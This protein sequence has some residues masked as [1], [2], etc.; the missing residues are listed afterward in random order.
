M[1]KPVLRRWFVAVN[2][3]TSPKTRGLQVSY[4]DFWQRAFRMISG[5]IPTGSPMVIPIIGRWVILGAF[6]L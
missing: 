1:V 6:V 3:W 2:T 4:R 5:P